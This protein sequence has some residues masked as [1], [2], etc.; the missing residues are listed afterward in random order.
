MDDALEAARDPT[1]SLATM[2]TETRGDSSP[3]DASAFSDRFDVRNWQRPA[4]GG[5]RGVDR[6][7]AA[8]L[9]AD[10]WLS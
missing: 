9:Y 7:L 1:S 2:Q 4:L 10:E 8:S 5:K 6:L 3:R